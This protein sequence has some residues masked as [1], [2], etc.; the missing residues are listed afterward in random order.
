MLCFA[1]GN[2]QDY[3]FRMADDLEKLYQ[4]IILEHYRTPRNACLIP[5]GEENAER[6]NPACGDRVRLKLGIEKGLLIRVEHETRGCAVSRASASLMSEHIQGLSVR[7]A[8]NRSR[9]FLQLME[10]GESDGELGNLRALL[11]IRDFPLRIRCAVLPWLALQDFLEKQ[12]QS[13]PEPGD[14]NQI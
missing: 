12:F 7:D 14:D 10:T 6:L 2:V 8:W 1:S 5:E 13:P 3:T 9:A 4:D 11:Q